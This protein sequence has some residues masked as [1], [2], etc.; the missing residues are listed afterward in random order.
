MSEMPSAFPSA[1]TASAC[2]DTRRKLL[3]HLVRER[4]LLMCDAIRILGS[5]DRAEDVVQDAALRCLKSRAIGDEVVCPG[6]MLRRMV[7]NLALD[8]LRRQGREETG[9]EDSLDP[10]CPAPPAE[11]RLAARQQLTAL[12]DAME[13]LPD[14][15]RRVF[16]DHRLNAR[17]QNQ[18]ARDMDL[19]PARIHAII[20]RTQEKLSEKMRAFD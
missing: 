9:A 3:D 1:P 20:R 19:S 10:V 2:A 14:S 7:R 8:H 12:I 4:E 13:T 6:G 16:L 11:Q 17:R 18:I 5:R 15:H